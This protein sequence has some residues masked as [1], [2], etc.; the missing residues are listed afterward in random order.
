MKKRK[1]GHSG[2]EVSAIGFGCMGM[3]MRSGRGPA[4]A[5]FSRQQQIYLIRAAHDFGVTFFDTAEA[6]GPYANEEL[7]GEA[8]APFRKDVTVATKFGFDIQG[9][10]IVGLNSRPEHIRRVAE[11]SL[12]RL[13]VEAID[14]FYQH[15]VDPDVPVEEVAGAVMDLI[16]EGKVK[17]FGLCET[18]AVT[19][20]CAHAVQPVSVVQAAYSPW[21]RTPEDGLLQTVEA[22][23]IGFVPSS[24]LGSGGLLTQL[25]HLAER[26]A[27]T[28]AQLALAW[29]LA[30]KPWVVPIPGTCRIGHADENLGGADV[31]LSAEDLRDIDAL[32][33]EPRQGGVDRAGEARQA[34]APRENLSA[35]FQC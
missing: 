31:K 17:H 3:G 18:S 16:R 10:Q 8:I 19:L 28:P 5:A 2:L 22:L 11:A 7:V 15:R 29:L 33:A 23:G 12:K 9:G 20:R 13:N 34:C 35:G 4:A 1:L 21:N 32:L 25:S 26:K 6:Y 27:A 30:Q 24:P 14:L